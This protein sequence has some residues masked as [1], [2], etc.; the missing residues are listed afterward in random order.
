MYY[1][2]T[3]EQFSN[4]SESVSHN[5]A[6]TLDGT[7]CILHNDNSLSITEFERVFNTNHEVNDWRFNPDTE[8]WRNWMTEE[9]YL[10]E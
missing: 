1:L 10:G 9:E 8:E 7:K 2:L 3:Q 6:W 5:V 4:W